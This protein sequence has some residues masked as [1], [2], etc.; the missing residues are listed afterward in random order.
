MARIPEPLHVVARQGTDMAHLRF[1]PASLVLIALI[2]CGP[3]KPLPACGSRP[4][5]NTLSTAEKAALADA[6]ARYGG[7]C[8]GEHQCGI[9]LRHNKDGHISVLVNSVY[10]DRKTGKCL[11]RIGAQNLTEY[12]ADGQFIQEHLML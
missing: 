10:A 2:G 8:E 11:Y 4:N 3:P 7:R 12:S 1:L 6:L 9:S 5:E